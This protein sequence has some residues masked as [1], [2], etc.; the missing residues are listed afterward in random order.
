MNI[1]ERYK[2]YIAKSKLLG[3]NME[4]EYAIKQ[5]DVILTKYKGTSKDV[6]IPPFITVIGV[7][8][9][10]NTGIENVE[11]NDGLRLIE[12]NAFE[13][14]NLSKVEIPESVRT[15]QQSAFTCNKG[16]FVTREIL[17]NER[18]IV[19]GDNTTVYNQ[20]VSHW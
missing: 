7:D 4:F 5:E 16:L 17:S 12:L 15:V 1:E 6:V 10:K 2:R 18:F 9:F 14:C 13:N 8:A 3:K 19:K 11:F 20:G